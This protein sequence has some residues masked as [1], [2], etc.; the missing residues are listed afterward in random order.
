MKRNMISACDYDEM[1]RKEEYGDPD[2]DIDDDD[3]SY[4]PYWLEGTSVPL[5]PK[6]DTMVMYTYCARR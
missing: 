5:L 3:D 6:H 4:D 1:R 2:C